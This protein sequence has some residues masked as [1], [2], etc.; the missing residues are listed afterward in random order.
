[1]KEILTLFFTFLKIGAFTFGGGYA[2][3]PLIQHEMVEKKK[4]ITNEEMMDIIAIAESTPGVLA[5][6]SA[7]FVGYKIRKFWGSFFAT[8]GVILPSMIIIT[9]IA[10]FFEDFLQYEY[11]IYAFRGI[12]ACVA[13][14]IFHAALRIAK[15][16]P[17]TAFSYILIAVAL[18]ASIILQIKT[19]YIIIFG[20]VIGIVSQMIILKI[21]EK[22][23]TKEEKL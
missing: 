17:K 1:M 8:L 2:M 13:A 15:H 14:L 11:V 6:N 20:L 10:I 9:I 22:K 4:W 19:T 5:V 12:R 21:K 16:F 23:S 7:T 18:V 3:I